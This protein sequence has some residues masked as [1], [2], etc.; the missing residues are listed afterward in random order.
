MSS[1]LAKP[2]T[3]LALAAAM[4]IAPLAVL[5]Q[6]EAEAGAAGEAEAIAGVVQPKLAIEL[7]APFC[8]NAV[9]QREMEVPV[10]GWSK[11]GTKITVEFAGQKL[12]AEAGKDG[13]WML[14]LK[15][16]KAS[17]S[18]QEMVI[19]DSDGKT[20]VLKNIL[21][22]EV[23]M[24]SGQSNMQLKVGGKGVDTIRLA[25]EF[26]KKVTEPVIREFEVTSV[27]AMLH[28]I[29]RAT[30]SW[31]NGEYDDYSAIAFAFAHRLY[32]ELQVPIGILN[33]SFSQTA[34]QAWTPRCGFRDAKDEY[35]KAIHQKCLQTDPATTEHKDAWGNF[36][37]SLED[38]IAE[39]EVRAKKG[40]KARA[41]N[42]EVPGNM[43]GNRDANWLFCGRLNP[44]VPYAMR[45]AIWNQGYANINEGIL[46]YNNL[47]SLI[48]GWRMVWGRPDLPVYFHQFY[49]PGQNDQPGIGSMSEMRLGAWL[50]RDIP[51]A[52][53]ASQIDISGAI[54]YGNKTLPGRRLALH[55]L[56]NQYGKEIVAEGPMYK[57]YEVKGDQVI[58]TFDHA[59]GGLVVADTEFNRNP[60]NE[61]STGL[62]DPKIMESG[63]DRVKLFWLAGEDRVWHPATVRI[64]GDQVVATSAGVKQPR[65]ISYGSGGIGFQPCL[66]NKALL[67]MTPFIYYDKELVT[68]KTWPDGRLKIAGEPI[69]PRTVGKRQ[70]YQKMPLVSVQFCDNAVLQAD[71]PVTI[72]GSTRKYGEWQS[73]PEPGQCEVRF[74]F[75]DTKRTIP[76]TPEMEEWNVILPPAKAGPTPYTLKVG[77]TIDGELVH[78]RVATNMVFGDVWYVAAPASAEDKSK[79]SSAEEAPAGN[80]SAPMVRM[81]ENQSKRAGNSSPSRFSISVSRAPDSKYASYWKPAS[82]LAASIGN[83]LAAKAGRPVG[84]L[85]MQSRIESGGK[86]K[87]SVDNATLSQWI[88]PDFLKE[89]PSLMGAY[90]TVGSK[91]PDHPYYIENVRR[92]IGDWKS[93]WGQ[94][95]PE[96]IATRAVPDRAPWGWYPSPAPKTGDSMATQIYNIYV[97]PFSPAALRGVIFITSDGMTAGDGGANFG[98]EMSALANCL[99]M[100]FGGDDIPFIYTVPGRDKAPK[101]SKPEKIGGRS[102]GVE[103]GIAE[104]IDAAVKEVSK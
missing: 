93:Y 39:N 57:S 92:Y 8:D 94:Y 83:S 102:V 56:K 26:R 69:D 13:K 86:G 15:P 65:G 7:G 95:I 21:V 97:C 80:P 30:G 66:Y 76:V 44:V 64:E 72:W 27:Y 11:P 6:E 5:A 12:E 37:K 29:E 61:A 58:V 20:V 63:A 38:Q 67:P 32:E 16:L 84:I 35:T 47:H 22:G 98:P 99:K 50:A 40:E 89:A 18:P 36:Y 96:M 14:R 25:A 75:G 53:M 42:A 101:L 45:G 82:G 19:R 31:K 54:H 43:D 59:E 100:K 4:M 23:W 74:E 46:Y 71:K 28:P 70:E 90:K 78:E 60:K 91:Y 34:I 33:C 85:F 17:A 52:G 68:S 9:L 87:P 3:C 10:W 77:F 24:A 48:G 88:S 41:I 81:M 104:L 55:A 79:K 62:A 51:N 103:G 2:A 73:K 49:C 1:R